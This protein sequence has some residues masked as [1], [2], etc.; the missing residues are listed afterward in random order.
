MQVFE[1][2]I[3]NG[4]SF[5]P[6]GGVI[7]ITARRCEDWVEVV[8]EDDG[9]GIPAASI[10]AIFERFYKDRPEGETFG[11]HSGLGLS[12]S[13]QIIEAHGGVIFAENRGDDPA[14]PAG[15]RFILRL[16]L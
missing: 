10:D 2:L 13:K 6:D 16:P 8:F 9:P 7:S 15:A 5:S 3:A 12:I 11:T 1:N 14:N 4:R